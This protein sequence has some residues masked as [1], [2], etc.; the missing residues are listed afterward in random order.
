MCGS[1][2]SL[3]FVQNA[4]VEGPATVIGNAG[5]STPPF[6]PSAL[7][8]VGIFAGKVFGQTDTARRGFGP[9]AARFVNLAKQ[10]PSSWSSGACGS[11]TAGTPASAPDGTMNA[12]TLTPASGLEGACFYSGALP[13]NVGDTFLYGGW[14]RS[15][16]SNGFG[17]FGAFLVSTNTPGC[18]FSAWP[19]GR[20]GSLAQTSPSSGGA[21]EWDWV[22]GR[23]QVTANGSGSCVFADNGVVYPANPTDYFA[24]LLI[25]I[26][27]GT[28]TANED[29][30]ICRTPSSLSS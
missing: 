12:G 24:P 25:D 27:N 6:S 13:V 28:L 11:P 20:S 16:H 4:T 8:Q 7:G 5:P 30:R 15:D 23:I 1:C 14:V 18:S 22:L 10:S 9:V 29:C 17:R 3:P 19:G 26:P 21:G 2:P